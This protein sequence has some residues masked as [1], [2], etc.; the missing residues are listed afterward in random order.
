MRQV[1]GGASCAAGPAR[2]TLRGRPSGSDPVAQRAFSGAGREVAASAPGELKYQSQAAWGEKPVAVPTVVAADAE[3]GAEDAADVV[4]AAGAGAADAAVA[5]A[6]PADQV[7]YGTAPVSFP[8][9]HTQLAEPAGAQPLAPSPL[10]TA[11]S[12]VPE[13]SSDSCRTY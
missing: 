5:A 13:S 12:Q 2:T 6:G 10:E 8:A 11:S 3:T 4:D 1:T 7:A 9:R